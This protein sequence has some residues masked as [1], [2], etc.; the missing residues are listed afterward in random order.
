ME[1]LSELN[2]FANHWLKH[3]KNG[4]FQRSRRKEKMSEVYLTYPRPA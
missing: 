4:D 3:K 1:R 2:P